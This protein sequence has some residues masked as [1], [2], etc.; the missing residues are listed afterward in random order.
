MELIFSRYRNLTVLL[1]V[2]FSQL[3]LLAYQVRSSTQLR[4]L[5]V[6]AVTG[7]APFARFLEGGRSSIHSFFNDYFI[8]LDVREENRQFKAETNR[9][10]LENNF[11][12]TELATADRARALIEFK[13]RS[14]SKTLA[15]RIIA[16]STSA[17]TVVLV[18]RGTSDGVYKGMAVITG[19]G[20]IGKVIDSFPLAAQVQLISDPLFG[21]GVVSQRNRVYG[22]LKGQGHNRC[23]IDRIQNEDKVELGE[24]FY[25]TGEDRIFPKGL[26]VGR[27][28]SVQTGPI[29]KNVEV[30][31]AGFANGLEEILIVLEGAHQEIPTPPSVAD[32]ITILQ[33]PPAAPASDGRSV[34]VG[35]PSH[36][37]LST[38]AD[39]LAERYMKKE[40]QQG[41]KFGTFGSKP[42]NFST[43]P[44]AGASAPPAAAPSAIP[45]Q[46]PPQQQQQQPQPSQ[47]QTA[48][49]ASP[50]PQAPKPPAAKQQ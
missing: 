24:M 23:L 2:L 47:P 13:G 32:Q 26:P 18:D 9:L 14:P 36:G 19:D 11:L 48:T 50:S 7:V 22:T 10:K 17:K 1:F 39:R 41:V 29:F 27:V 3:L 45:Q 46:P 38:D 43:L 16:T 37:V 42:P 31:P 49:P 21:A 15:A 34:P 35:T 40:E 25:T 8:L 20:I 5:R 4:T 33:A 44:P 28:V 6:W 30:V 12:R